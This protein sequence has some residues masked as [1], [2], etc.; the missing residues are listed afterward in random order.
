MTTVAHKSALFCP[1]CAVSDWM[2][3]SH[4]R[5]A[6]L[7]RCR[8]CGLLA[9]TAFVHRHETTDSLYDIGPTQYE[10]YATQYLPH[11][12]ASFERELDT[13]EPFRQTGRLLEVGS[14]FGF[15]LEAASRRG[16]RAEGVEVSPYGCELAR[17]RGHSV[18]QGYLEDAPLDEGQFDV[19]ALW[20]VIEH[21]TTPA[22]MIKHCLR[23]LR[24]GG[25]LVLKT[26]DGRALDS[27]LAPLRAAY[28]H[29]VYPANTAEHVFH[30]SPQ[31]LQQLVENVGFAHVEI[32]TRD[33]WAER[34]ISGNAR[35]VRAIRW[36]IMRRA[37]WGGWPYEFALRAV[38]P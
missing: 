1:T 26:P 3:Q 15:F 5:R 21:V 33:E 32:E 22:P 25:R 31:Q 13:L 20:D 34:V 16:W 29:F 10:E 14:G 9:T 24:P 35:W 11:R 17:G 30:F 2:P 6:S 27:T 36:L 4:V 8:R 28:R 38:K 37:F 12:R 18:Y 23:L 19:V 7:S